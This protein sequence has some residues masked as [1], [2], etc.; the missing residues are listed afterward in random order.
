MPPLLPPLRT[1]ATATAATATI[2][3]ATTLTATAHHLHYH[4]L[5]P[6]VATARYAEPST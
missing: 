5:P 1:I 3:T 4:H 6:A 2:T